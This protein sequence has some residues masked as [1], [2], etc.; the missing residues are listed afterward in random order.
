MAAHIHQVALKDVAG[1]GGMQ[2]IDQCVLR[3]EQIIGVVPLYGLIQ[4]W[5]AKQQNQSD[6]NQSRSPN[7]VSCPALRLAAGSA[8]TGR[9]RPV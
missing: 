7:R 3:A 8:T 9:E 1:I 6:D 2:W 5:Q 4:E